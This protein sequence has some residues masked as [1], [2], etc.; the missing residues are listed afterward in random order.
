MSPPGL[1]NKPGKKP[2]SVIRQS[3]TMDY[4]ALYAESRTLHNHCYK[5]IKIWDLLFM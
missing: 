5:N 3:L 2:A 4:M 1:K